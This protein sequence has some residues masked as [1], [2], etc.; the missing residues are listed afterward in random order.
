MTTIIQATGATRSSLVEI[1]KRQMIDTIIENFVDPSI[2]SN[3]VA[4][5]TKANFGRPAIE[6]LADEVALIASEEIGAVRAK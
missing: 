4:A 3:V 1:I 2:R 6:A 5:L